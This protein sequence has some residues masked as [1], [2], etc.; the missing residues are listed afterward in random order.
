MFIETNY[1][2]PL[3]DAVKLKLFWRLRC[4]TGSDIDLEYKADYAVSS[5]E[6]HRDEMM[7]SCGL[8]VSETVDEIFLRDGRSRESLRDFIIVSDNII[9]RCSLV[10]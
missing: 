2:Q 3:K 10:V 9:D 5:W 4:F 6:L 7:D 1:K 8:M